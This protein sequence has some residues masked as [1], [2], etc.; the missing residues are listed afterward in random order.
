MKKTYLLTP[1]PTPVPSKVLE[2]MARP[3][4]HHRTS[5]FQEIFKEVNEN[6]KYLFCTKEDVLTFASSGT[7]A[8]EGCVANLLNRGDTAVVVNGGKFGER[9]AEI[10]E[11]Y[12]IKTIAIDIEWGTA[13]D[14]L[15]IETTLKNNPKV[16]AVFITHCET[17]TG[18][19]TDVKS[20]AS[21]TSKTKAVLVVDAISSLGAMELPKDKWNVDVVVSGSQKGLMIPPG[22]AFC[23][24]NN[25]AWQLVPESKF[26]KYYFDFLKARKSA[27]K[28]DTPYTPAVNLI[29]GLNEALRMIK[30]EG[31]ESVLERHERLAL[32]T[33]RGMQA[34]GL[35][36]FS[37]SPA[38]SVTAVKSPD[39]VDSAKLVKLLRTEYGISIAGGQADLKGKIFRIAHLGYMNEFDIIVGI[40]A[41]GTGL[42]ELG[43][44]I[45]TGKG[46]NAAQEIFNRHGAEAKI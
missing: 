45:D 28:N 36:L 34:M 1:G 31:L 15:R 40:A 42:S 4:I 17:S 20:I 10:C 7:G 29:I 2:A 11:T 14:P 8:M 23:A 21:I 25:K 44:K 3:I 35:G 33:R 18:T 13:I 41:V 43:Y 6:L 27:Q 32:A 46:I 37:K 22:L 30:T 9:W 5:E 38:N 24:L 26:P 16:K 39:S 12:G 19:K